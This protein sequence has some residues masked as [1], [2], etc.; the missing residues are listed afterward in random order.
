MSPQENGREGPKAHRAL[1]IVA[2]AAALLVGISAVRYTKSVTQA[3]EATLR[4]NLHAL[5]EAI[6]Q[7]HADWGR[8]PAT[9]EAL[10]QDEYLRAVP[11]DPI[12]GSTLTWRTVSEIGVV[13]ARSGS[14]LTASDGSR[15]ADW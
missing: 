2:M 6:G 12:T 14:N 11:E 5:N 9:L 10:V 15:Y 4:T 3:K 1:I 7:Y 13:K 8:Y